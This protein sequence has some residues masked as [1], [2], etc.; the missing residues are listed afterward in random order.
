MVPCDICQSLDEDT[1]AVQT[2][3]ALDAVVACFVD[4]F[5]VELVERLDVVAGESDGDEDEVC[6]TLFHVIGDCVA[7]LRAEPGGGTDLGLPDE[8]VRV[9]VGEAGHDRV[10]GCGDFG[11]IGV[12]YV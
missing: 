2:L 6:L 3:D 9:A 8:P 11:R 5:L 4:D 1:A 12:A 7:G 10:D